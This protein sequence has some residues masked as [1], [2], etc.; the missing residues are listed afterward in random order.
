MTSKCRN[1]C[2]EPVRFPKAIFNRPGLP[3]IDYRIGTYADFRAAIMAQLNESRVL[4]GWTH[5]EGDDPGIALLEGASILGDILTLYQEVY[6]NE[7]YLRTALWR[8]SVADL[9]Q[10]TGY[11]LSPGVG[12]RA[13][14]AFAFKGDQPSTI[15]AGFPVKAQVEG[16][17]APVVFETAESATA[18]PRLNQFHLYRPHRFAAVGNHTAVFSVPLA[19]V[20]EQGLDLKERDRLFLVSDP[21][22][23][24]TKR[25]VVVVKR[26]EERFDRFE[27]EIEGRWRQGGV[28]GGLH[29]YKLG[30][31]FR[32]FGYNGPSEKITASGD[33]V[34]TE[35][36]S[37]VRQLQVE[38][39]AL[40]ILYAGYHPLASFAAM[41][42]SDE[43]DDVSV[44]TTMLVELQLA[45][46]TYVGG[47]PYFFERTVEQT[48]HASITWG[49]LSGGSTVLE[50][51]APPVLSSTYYTD[52]RSVS[53]HEVE[54]GS[55]TVT[56]QM[57]EAPV[58]DSSVLYHFGDVETYNELDER[59]LLFEK[60]DG[61]AAA[62]TVTVEPLTGAESDEV[63]LRPVYLS[64]VL[65]HFGLDDFP[66]RGEAPVAVYGNLAEATQ[67]RTEAE[68]TLGNGDSREAFQTFKLPNAPLTYLNA[69]GT[70]PPEIPEL[71]VFVDERRWEHVASFFGQP[72]EAEVY[73]VREDAEENSWVQFGD[74]KTGRR[75]PTGREN[76]VARYRTGIGAHG[77]RK[78]DTAV[79]PGRRLDRLEKIYL[80]GIASG[81][82]E[83]EHEEKAREAAPGKMQSL[84]RLVSLK[85]FESETLA[86]PGVDRVQA[87][88]GLFDNVPG[89]ELTVLMEQ[90]R[91]AE[92]DAV[93]RI[94]V[95]YSRC[96]GARRF[97]IHVRQGQRRYVYVDVTVAIGPALREEN[98]REAVREALGAD[99]E[100]GH[101]G[102]GLFSPAY[103]RFGQGERA[104][105]VEGVVQNVE[106]VA[107]A[108]AT[109]FGVLGELADPL[110]LSHPPAV[111]AREDVI[112]CGSA[113]VLALYF[114][115][116]RLNVS[117]AEDSTA[118]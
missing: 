8:E 35:S 68:V 109:A 25:Q 43:V 67:G 93:R 65:E 71:D 108:R 50:L 79:Q 38:P 104:S 21:G 105:T 17:D 78:A 54:G 81:G 34:V 15:P 7:A 39:D 107:W 27:I 76:V 72:P 33:D 57:E 118:C 48:E 97:P 96:R 98:I 2:L 28:S 14:F 9:V 37:F 73:V 56:G 91:E 55:F 84:G 10:L 44:G 80:P 53:L 100:D 18:H 69:V 82:D 59:T 52:I 75:L 22:D 20:E 19:E 11:R 24:A 99:G 3:R 89:I 47:V 116:L 61:T 49:A 103:R 32:H 62:S 101:A 51:D 113:R 4:E 111:L 110:D 23:P 88:W 36:V 6:A 114:S 95:D 85:D 70:T 40:I 58:S 42:L 60:E 86:I 63:T 5:R 102:N 45:A 83:P 92:I 29:G 106:G 77:A 87:A 117:R 30:R 74:G 90:G 16:A 115:H 41:P 13:V 66:L 112:S 1:D 26:V 94:L 31:T 64:E 46:S 12:G